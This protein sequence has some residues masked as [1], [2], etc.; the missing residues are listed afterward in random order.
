[1]VKKRK[2][3]WV[4]IIPEVKGRLRNAVVSLPFLA[5]FII[6]V[7]VISGIGIWLPYTLDETGK[8]VFFETQNLLTYSLAFLGTMIV[9]LL[10]SDKK[11]KDLISLSLIFG[12]VAI[13]LLV[14]GYIAVPK[15]FSWCVLFGSVITILMFVFFTVNDP[16]YDSSEQDGATDVGVDGFKEAK[17]ENIKDKP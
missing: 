4:D 15:G 10:L 8:A 1:M 17:L 5:S 12:V 7:L 3:S 2:N 16:K 13:F 9:D 11:N 14:S 6:G